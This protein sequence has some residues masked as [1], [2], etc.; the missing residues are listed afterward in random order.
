M[1]FIKIETKEDI[2]QLDQELITKNV[3]GIDTEFRRTGKE[4]INLSLIQVNDSDETY[5]IDCIAIGKYKNY[6]GFLFSNEV[7]KIFHSVRE[8][9]EAIYSWSE[10]KV[11]NVFDT[12]L[13][14]AFLGGSFPI[15]YKD[16]VNE[17]FGFPVDKS[18]TRSNWLKRPLRDSQ[19]EYAASDVEFLI[20]LYEEQNRELQ[21]T[22]KIGWLFEE[23]SHIS[24]L[25]FSRDN[26]ESLKNNKK[27]TKSEEQKYLNKFNKLIVSTSK[28]WQI[29]STIL[30]SKKNQRDFFKLLL[31]SNLEFCL[32]T[33]PEWK[34]NLLENHF[35]EIFKQLLEE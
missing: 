16:L 11:I 4:N 14:N 2:N 15:A 32:S 9:I 1:S 26:Q 12:Q 29:N 22:K 20:E 27:L 17:K 35:R 13:A 33:L 8:D 6:C 5:L 30:F 23:V 25:I 19:L 3:L 10:N 31:K 18:E 7:I 34:V 24:D 28:K 21:E